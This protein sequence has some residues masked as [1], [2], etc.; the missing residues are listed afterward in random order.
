M[1]R[2]VSS[3]DKLCLLPLFG[4]LLLV[5][6][7]AQRQVFYFSPSVA[8]TQANLS[9][10]TPQEDTPGSPAESSKFSI[11]H[12]AL[13][14][15]IA[16]PTPAPLAS[17]TVLA[18]G[19][20][21]KKRSASA[22]VK[23]LDR[24]LLRLHK[25]VADTTVQQGPFHSKLP[26]P[27]AST[28]GVVFAGMALLGWLAVLTASSLLSLLTLLVFI[29]SATLIAVLFSASGEVKAEK[30]PEKYNLRGAK[31]AK[32]LSIMASVILVLALA[33]VL[34]L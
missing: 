23:K 31:A 34:L 32:A 26:T 33:G 10:G 9:E 4:L 7:C 12:N 24:Q 19:M 25:Q 16:P 6:G 11:E 14:A 20:P 3:L 2:T 30:E 27:K 8:Q 15:S 28:I 17:R 22:N 5:A 13:E 29:I 21:A 1:K 18:S